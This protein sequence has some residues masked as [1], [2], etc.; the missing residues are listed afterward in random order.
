MVAM[1]S[2][3]FVPGNRPE[4]FHK[5]LGLAPDVFVPDLEDSVPDSEKATARDTVASLLPQLHEAG[6]PV[7]PRINS[8]ESGLLEE[9]IAAV[10][11]PHTYGVTVGKTQSARDIERV[12]S[13]VAAVE[14]A[15]KLAFGAVRLV[16]WI[17]TAA[18]VVNAYEICAASPR[19]VAVAFGAEDFARDMGIPRTEDAAEA[20]YPRSVVCVAARAANVLALDTPFFRFRDPDGLRRDALAARGFGFRGKFAIHPSQIDIINDA[21]RP[22][23]EEV[24]HARNVVR[25]A[26]E[27]ERLGR[28]STS[29]DGSVI[30]VPVVKRA[31]DLLELA[32]TMRSTDQ[33]GE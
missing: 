20:A 14:R 31:R 6:S 26:E 7:M 8:L 2:L 21:F 32:E 30:D 18:A 27:A 22:S 17:E 4:M 1:R 13:V 15:A 11:G 9:D 3:L 16:P 5:A 23:S 29:L 12:A 19:V 28:G 24:E 10:V 33:A 25:A